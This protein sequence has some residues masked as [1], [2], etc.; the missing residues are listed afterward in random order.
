M[1]IPGKTQLVENETVEM[2]SGAQEGQAYSRICLEAQSEVA[3][4][5]PVT[6][7]SKNNRIQ[8]DRVSDISVARRDEAR[9]QAQLNYQ[10]TVDR[11]YRS[12]I[13]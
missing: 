3:I 13:S 7:Q 2:S 9:I 6:F 8:Y 11:C 4:E 10:E 5:L 12:L 1:L